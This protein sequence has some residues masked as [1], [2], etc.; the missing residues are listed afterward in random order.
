M[1]DWPIGRGLHPLF[2]P[3]SSCLGHGRLMAHCGGHR[4]LIS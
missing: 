3:A 4:G 1:A 2:L